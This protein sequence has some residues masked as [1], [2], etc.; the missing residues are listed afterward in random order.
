MLPPIMLLTT[1]LVLRNG[2]CVISAPVASANMTTERC[3]DVPMPEE[4]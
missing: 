1:S 2:M 3:D 4:P